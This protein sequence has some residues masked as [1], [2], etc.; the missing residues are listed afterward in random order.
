MN[1]KSSEHLISFYVLP[2][3]SL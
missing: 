2:E 1:L 3:I